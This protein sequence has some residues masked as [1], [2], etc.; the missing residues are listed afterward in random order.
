MRAEHWY[1]GTADAV[2]QQLPHLKAQNM[3]Y[4]LI[5]AGDHLYQMD[6]SKFVNYHRDH[7]AEVTV[8]VK[9]VSKRR[10]IGVRNP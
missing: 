6:Y 1:Q 8:A 2:R 10:G 7:H 5:L 3:D 9:P 4:I